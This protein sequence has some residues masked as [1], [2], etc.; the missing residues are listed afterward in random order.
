MKQNLNL[1]KIIATVPD[2]PN[3]FYMH[4][5][6]DTEEHAIYNA[7]YCLHHRFPM[8]DIESITAKIVDVKRANEP[9][10]P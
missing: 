8:Y 10:A 5:I 2:A 1:Y 9:I 7:K 6:T 3:C 4:F